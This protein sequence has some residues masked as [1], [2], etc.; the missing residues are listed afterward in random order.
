M[1]AY[2]TFL[3]PP[4]KAHLAHGR[5]L[6][7]LLNFQPHDLPLQ[8]VVPPVR[9]VCIAALI[10]VTVEHTA[11]Q[12]LV[13]TGNFPMG[14]IHPVHC[15]GGQNL[16]AVCALPNG[17]EIKASIVKF[18]HVVFLA[19][20]IAVSV[21]NGCADGTPVPVRLH[22]HIADIDSST[23]AAN[24]LRSNGVLGGVIFWIIFDMEHIALIVPVKDRANESL[25]K[26]VRA[27]LLVPARQQ[28]ILICKEL[29]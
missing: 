25:S 11:S 9:T 28:I 29:K 19:Y 14:D 10:G 23:K 12:I 7:L 3:W 1:H 27:R 5:H 13:W 18:Q 2:R 15:R 8:P 17:A 16:R 26:E 20:R 24:N 6:L 21:L 22:L 4:A